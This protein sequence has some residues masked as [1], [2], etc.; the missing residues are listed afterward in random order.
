MERVYGPAG[1]ARPFVSLPAGPAF[2]EGRGLRSYG[3]L[4]NVLF[5]FAVDHPQFLFLPLFQLCPEPF[6]LGSA[7]GILHIGIHMRQAL[8]ELGYL[9]YH[10]VM[11][12]LEHDNL[13]SVLLILKLVQTAF[14]VNPMRRPGKKI[15]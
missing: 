8:R 7:C 13:L 3:A 1:K 15:T 12:I 4:F 10:V 5:K 2:N 6:A 9:L 11:Q 14:P